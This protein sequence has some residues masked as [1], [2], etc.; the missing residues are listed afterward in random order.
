MRLPVHG[1]LFCLRSDH[2]LSGW[3]RRRGCPPTSRLMGHFATS[4]EQPLVTRLVE[5]PHRRAELDGTFGMM[6]VGGKRKSR[7][8]SRQRLPHVFLLFEQ[9]RHAGHSDRGSRQVVVRVG[10]RFRARP[11]DA[12][13]EL[14]RL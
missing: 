11:V 4:D 14:W 8:P 3:A 7:V 6:S 2:E 10:T 1:E 5:D 12:I 13:L 9:L